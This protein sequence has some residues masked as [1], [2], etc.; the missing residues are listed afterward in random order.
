MRNRDKTIAQ[1]E[2]V[3]TQQDLL[4]IAVCSKIHKARVKWRKETHCACLE[5]DLCTESL[6][7]VDACLAALNCELA[8]TWVPGMTLPNIINRAHVLQRDLLAARDCD[9]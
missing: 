6:C 2:C 8:V 4:L 9:A 7:K 1:L 3:R 5:T